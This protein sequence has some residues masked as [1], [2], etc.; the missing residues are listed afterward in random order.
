MNFS[1]FTMTLNMNAP[2]VTHKA[3]H[4][5]VP[6]III[7]IKH[8]DIIGFG[9]TV[10]LPYY[11]YHLDEMQNVF[12][13][14]EKCNL[15]FNQTKTFHSTNFEEVISEIGKIE[16]LNLNIYSAI[17][18]ALLDLFSKTHKQSLHEFLGITTEKKLIS[19]MTLGIKTLDLLKSDLEK[20]MQWPVLKIKM[21]A[22]LVE[23]LE[24][25]KFIRNY[26][27]G[28]IR[29]DANGSWDRTKAIFMLTELKDYNI[30]FIEQPIAPQQHELLREL[31]AFSE[32]PLFVDED[33]QNMD[34]LYKLA[35]IVSGVNIQAYKSGGLTKLVKMLQEAKKLGLKTMLGCQAESCLGISALAHIASLADYLDLDG[36]LDFIDDKFTGIEI[37]NGLITL[38]KTYGIGAVYHEK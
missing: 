20:Y 38:P 37:E 30:E 28:N 18:M 19:S 29:I 1:F 3:T 21:S 14:L 24:K 35:G 11:Y 4:V 25:I 26:Y 17:E 7:Q 23:N 6:H 16:N 31:N 27:N 5:K 13:S 32:I 10:I 2:F 12:Q 22:N 9:Q 36:H 15:F 8:N 34:D 33:C